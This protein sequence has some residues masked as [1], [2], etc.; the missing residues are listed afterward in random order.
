MFVIKNTH[1]ITLRLHLNRNAL[2]KYEGA[3]ALS[4]VNESD[5]LSC[6]ER[7]MT[8]VVIII[9][10]SHRIAFSELNAKVN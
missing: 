3:I 10:T 1:H 8:V 6:L 5:S 7:Q 4:L 2:I 9:I